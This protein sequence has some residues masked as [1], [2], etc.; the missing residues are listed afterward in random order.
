MKKVP[1]LLLCALLSLSLRAGD[2]LVV[3]RERVGT[4]LLFGSRIVE[5]NRP[6]GKVFAAG[7][8]NPKPVLA[9]FVLRD[10]T[11][12]LVPEERQRKG[13]THPR[14]FRIIE[15][16]AAGY[17]I[18]LLPNFSTYPEEISAVPPKMLGG[19]AIGYK[20]ISSGT[21]GKYLHITGSYSYEGGLELTACCYLIYLRRFPMAGRYPDSDKVGYTR[22]G[23]RRVDTM[24]ALRW[25][26][27]GGRKL[28]FYA[29]R[30]FPDE[31]FP[32]IREGV[33]D[34][35]KAFDA[36]GLCN[37]LEV[38]HEPDGDFDRNDPLVNMIRWMDVEESNAKGDV[39]FDPRSGEILQ[40]DILWWKN[41]TDLMCGWR[42]VQTGAADPAARATEYPIE[43]LGPMIRHAVCHE[44]GHALGLSHN[45]GASWAYPADSLRSVSFT[46]KYGTSASV[47][48][49]AR[50]NHLATAADVAAGVNL[51][52]PR[53]GP[54]DYYAI[55]A[56]YGKAE[57]DEAGDYCYYAPFISAAISPDPS[58]QAE[59]LGNDLLRSSSAGLANCRALL[60]LDGLTPERLTLIKKYYYNYIWLSLSNIGGITCGQ[61]A[62]RKVCYKTLEFVLS[63]LAEAPE[64]IYDIKQEERILRELDGNFLPER[65]EKNL[66][67]AELKRY[68]R[69]LEKLKKKYHKI[70]IIHQNYV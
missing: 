52:P 24:P 55:A 57:P 2:T 41:V 61:P 6:K 22:T 13:K 25:D 18:D 45:M 58:A 56:G 44:M 33:E 38:R 4:P 28:V 17:R 42:Y 9:R 11:L 26:L 65:I 34:W 46:R 14:E 12:V 3:P 8:R 39:L 15:E 43:I 66:G 40:A 5:V 47:M 19:K 10:S 63:A 31:W 23:G 20:I 51:L 35:N 21:T 68:M 53:L 1:L 62:T 50:Y 37:V 30:R 7:Q 29:D 70:F 32:Y 64:A 60:E 69:R 59:T 49:Y 27:S 16:T 67:G 48:D 36:I 54:Y